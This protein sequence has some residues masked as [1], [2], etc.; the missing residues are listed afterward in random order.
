MA[1][2]IYRSAIAELF[3]DSAG[4]KDVAYL[5]KW[6]DIYQHMEN[7][8]DSCEDIADILEGVVLKYA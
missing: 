5:V 8:I 7:A 3:A 4:S 6:R 1:D 2:D